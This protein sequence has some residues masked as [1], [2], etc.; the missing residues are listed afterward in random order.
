[1]KLN[2]T[3]SEIFEQHDNYCSHKQSSYPFVYDKIFKDAITSQTPITL[4]EIGVNNG[5]SLEIWKKYLPTGSIIH[6]VDINQTCEKLK[7]S[8]GIYF[9]LGDQ[10]DKE[11]LDN[12]F[13][14]I[15]FD[16]I[17]DDGSHVCSHVIT[18][19]EVMFPKLKPGGKYIVE[20]LHTSYWKRFG[21]GYLK[22]TSSMEF[23]KNL[24]DA[25]NYDHIRLGRIDLLRNILC[26]LNKRRRFINYYQDSISCISFYDSIVVVEKFYSRKIEPFSDIH[27]GNI[28]LVVD[29]RQ[30]REKHPSVDISKARKCYTDTTT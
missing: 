22:K 2:E 19:F 10:I 15:E 12:T 1:M 29:V 21:G 4:L 25:L 28:S 3:Y 26:Q 17:I 8:E 27:T 11:F 23:F 9:H 13:K 30:G 6:G 20:D 5:G 16:V 14:D 7:F 24:L 18:T